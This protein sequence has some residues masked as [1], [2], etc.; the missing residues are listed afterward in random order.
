VTRASRVSLLV[1]GVGLVAF[2][3]RRAGPR[4]VWAM[5]VRTGWTFVPFMAIY[6]LHVALRAAALWRTML[7][8]QVR[9]AD[10]L[11]IRLAGEAVEMLTFTGPFLA[12]PAKGWLLARRGLATADAFAAVVTEY[13]LYTVASSWLAIVALWLLLARGTLSPRVESGLLAVVALTVA[14]L[15]AFTF[16]AVTGTGLI[17]PV[18]RFSRVLIGA[19]RAEHAAQGFTRVEAAI[20]RFLHEHPGRLTEVLAIETGAQLLL[21]LEIWIVLVA[22]GASRAWDQSF[23]LE[24]GVKFVA[25]AFAFIP[26]Q[27]GALEGVYALLAGAI[28][29]PAAVGLTLALLRR[30]RDLLVAA[31]GLVTV[32]IWGD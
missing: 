11:R 2:L 12:E 3:V 24:G 17:V 22:L 18:L 21:I 16:A 29:L 14:F 9:Y 19:Q 23:I 10:V 15:I 31:A 25:I 30:V 6:G 8:G 27:F 20:V 13:L 5:L 1:F 26:G 28:G 32:A 4:F 7:D